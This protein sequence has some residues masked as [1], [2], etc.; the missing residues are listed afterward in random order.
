[1][2]FTVLYAEYFTLWGFADQ[3]TYMKMT[4]HYHDMEDYIDYDICCISLLLLTF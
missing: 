2:H 1:M 4:N 3:V